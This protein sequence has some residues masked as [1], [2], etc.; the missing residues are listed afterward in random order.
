MENTS[1]IAK[2]KAAYRYIKCVVNRIPQPSVDEI[3]ELADVLGG[4]YGL[5]D[6]LKGLREE[7]LDPTD[8]LIKALS[9]FVGPTVSDSEISAKLIDPFKPGSQ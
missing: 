9:D 8:Q 6:A 7:I 5:K 3:T 2:R 1:H 4:V